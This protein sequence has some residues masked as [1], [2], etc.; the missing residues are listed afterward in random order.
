MTEV[1]I[2]G[3]KTGTGTGAGADGR[4]AGQSIDYGM[5]IRGGTRTSNS[6]RSTVITCVDDMEI[7]ANRINNGR[8]KSG[9]AIVSCRRTVSLDPDRS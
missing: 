6:L 4:W 3:T 7:F 9:C 1:V 2:I 5:S 8:V